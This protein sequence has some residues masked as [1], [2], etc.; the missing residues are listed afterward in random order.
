MSNNSILPQ[1]EIDIL[2][3]FSQKAMNPQEL[4]RKKILLKKNINW[5]YLIEFAHSQGVLLHFYYNLR[6]TDLVAQVP[7]SLMI[8]MHSVLEDMMKTTKER[9][10]YLLNGIP[11]VIYL[12]KNN[13]I[14]AIPY[15]GPLLSLKIYESIEL[16]EHADIDILVHQ[17]DY[18][19]SRSILIDRGFQIDSDLDLDWECTLISPDGNIVVDLHRTF[20]P[21]NF[22]IYLDFDK[23]WERCVPIYILEMAVQS[24]SMEDLIIVL[25]QY[26]MKDTAHKKIKL[27]QVSDIAGLIRNYPINW[28]ML[29][30][31]NNQMMPRHNALKVGL[32]V[33]DRLCCIAVPKEVRDWIGTDESIQSSA[34]MVI[35]EIFSDSAS[36]GHLFFQLIHEARC[37]MKFCNG[38]SG[39]LTTICLGIL[40]LIQTIT[41][42][43]D[44]EKAL[45]KLPDT[46]YYLY[47]F[48]R[49]IRLS[50]NYLIIRPLKRIL[51]WHP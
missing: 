26:T 44:K 1:S 30:E 3:A 49:P 37:I 14:R 4:E 22:G 19:R 15:K 28:P 51:E 35:N 43:T 12:F 47:Y 21:F 25:C 8:T 9:N 7:K 32:S 31:R 48:V 40:R 17:N 16:R 39:K 11:E 2:L 18:I 34:T 23:L 27:Y 36:K 5:N 24:L 50:I 13:N 20:L 41:V 42:P 33:A 10:S 38:W 46:L 29:I 6:N 45:F